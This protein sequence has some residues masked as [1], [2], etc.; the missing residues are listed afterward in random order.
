MIMASQLDAAQHILSKS[1]LKKGP[2][3]KLIASEAS[4]SMR[5]VQRIRLKRLQFE[6]PTPRTN[7]SL[8]AVYDSL[9][10]RHPCVGTLTITP[11]PA[12]PCPG[13]SLVNS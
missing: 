2:E 10:L 11:G 7:Y 9:P 13:R 1:L 4:Y 6:V 3:T 12:R 5:A 8:L